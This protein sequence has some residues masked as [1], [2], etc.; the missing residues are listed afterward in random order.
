MTMF[1]SRAE[2][3]SMGSRFENEHARANS[4]GIARIGDDAVVNDA[5]ALVQDGRQGALPDV[6]ILKLAVTKDV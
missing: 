6:K 3:L 4:Q 1:L 5:S 2:R